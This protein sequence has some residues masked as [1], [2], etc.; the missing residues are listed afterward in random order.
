MHEKAKFVCFNFLQPQKVK[1]KSVQIN[2]KHVSYDQA[3]IT[4][5]NRKRR[6]SNKVRTAASTTGGCFKYIL[7]AKS[8]LFR[9]L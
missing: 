3:I 7:R 6:I 1:F 5:R 8:Q 9:L 2:M 4:D